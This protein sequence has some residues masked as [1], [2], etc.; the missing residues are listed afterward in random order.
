MALALAQV[1]A[2]FEQPAAERADVVERRDGD[3]EVP[4][5]AADLGS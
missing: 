2:V 3:E 1:E 4:P 5:V